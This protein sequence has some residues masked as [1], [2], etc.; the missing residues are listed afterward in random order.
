MQKIIFKID[1]GLGK[2]IAGLGVCEAIKKAYPDS[3]LIV[4][5]G[6]PDAAQYNKFVD[7]SLAF[8]DLNYFYQHELLGE[9]EEP[10][11]MLQD[12]YLC[13]DFI[14]RK[15][16]LIENWCDINRIPYNGEIPKIRMTNY[17]GTHYDKV[18]HSE[19]PIMTIQSNGGGPGQPAYSW[20]RDMPQHIAQA[21]VD[22]YAKDYNI[23][24]FRREDQM[25]LNGVTFI[26]AANM[27]ALFAL[28]K[29]SKKRVFIDSFAQH[30]AAALGM[31]SVV[32][33][34]L[35]LPSQFGYEMHN[36]I[37]AAKPNLRLDYRNAIFSPYSVLDQP[38]DVPYESEKDLFDLDK[39]FEAIDKM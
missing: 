10:I 6:Y 33:W 14:N 12:P 34:I 23:V 29:M 39:I 22:R 7:K 11:F 17:E 24:H 18:F 9:K 30:A 26:Q 5:T 37:I 15:G 36:N 31:P 28:I 8:T 19:K 35:N 3:H 27:R 4:L 2:T 1:G 25:P 32:L 21:I 20:M 16:H 38:N 13:S